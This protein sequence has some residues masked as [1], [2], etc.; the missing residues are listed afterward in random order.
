MK[1]ILTQML[2]PIQIKGYL[3]GKKRVCTP[4]VLYLMKKKTKTKKNKKQKNHRNIKK[5]ASDF[6]TR[7]RSTPLLPMRPQEGFLYYT[8]IYVL[9]GKS[10]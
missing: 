6:S 9:V 3:L 5:S 2:V 7:Q 4:N 8:Y 1:P 10:C